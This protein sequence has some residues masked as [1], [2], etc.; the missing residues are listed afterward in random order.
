[1]NDKH[2]G[3]IT[4]RF[5]DDWTAVTLL[6]GSLFTALYQLAISDPIISL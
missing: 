4:D 1:M 2:F 6:F 5:S 3:L